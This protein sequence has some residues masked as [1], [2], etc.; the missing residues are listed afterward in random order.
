[1]AGGFLSTMFGPIGPAVVELSARSRTARLLVKAVAVSVFA[2]TLVVSE[3]LAS[4]GF[5][6]PERLSL[7]VQAMLTSLACQRPSGEPQLTDG[8]VLS[9]RTVRVFVL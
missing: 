9:R 2:G 1:M 6:S 4:A 7:A 5:A 8:A 3:K